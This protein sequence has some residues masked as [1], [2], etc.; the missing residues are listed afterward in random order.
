MKFKFDERTIS[1]GL[2]FTLT[3]SHGSVDLLGEIAGLDG[4]ERVQKYASKFKIGEDLFDVLS[5]EGLIRSKRAAG[6]SKDLLV[7]PEL[8]ALK[9]LHDQTD[10]P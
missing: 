4:F 6:R 7:I 2:N 5:L 3:T 9:E 1:N 10:L 8:Q